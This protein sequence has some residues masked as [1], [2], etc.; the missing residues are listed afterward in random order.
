MAVCNLK[1]ILLGWL[2]KWKARQ[3]KYR[4][5]QSNHGRS[6]SQEFCAITQQKMLKYGENG[7][8][9]ETLPDKKAL[10]K[11]RKC[12]EVTRSLSSNLQ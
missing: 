9:L 4:V 1:S 10:N 2:E 6:A 8:F 11:K 7:L 12:A 5:R 3:K